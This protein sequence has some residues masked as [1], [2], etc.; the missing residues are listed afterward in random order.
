MHVSFE[1]KIRRSLHDRAQAAMRQACRVPNRVE[2]DDAERD[3]RH[4]ISLVLLLRQHEQTMRDTESIAEFLKAAE[5]FAAD[6]ERATE[7]V[8]SIEGRLS[9]IDMTAP[10]AAPAPELEPAKPAEPEEPKKWIAPFDDPSRWDLT[11]EQ[12]AEKRKHVKGWGVV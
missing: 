4:A 3:A 1:P 9:K 5:S 12:W 8:G 11:P 10:A 7:A 2:R 6:A